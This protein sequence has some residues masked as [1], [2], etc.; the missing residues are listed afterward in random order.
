MFG[1][2]GDLQ[3]THNWKLGAAVTPEGLQEHANAQR[4]GGIN[5]W[6]YESP[7]EDVIV[8]VD[9]VKQLVETR[10][11]HETSMELDRGLSD[12]SSRANEPFEVKHF[13]VL[14]FPA[15]LSEILS[16]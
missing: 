15:F 14:I 1:H 7:F 13:A 4:D 3:D 12:I 16:V 8:R 11:I 2:F 9:D 6:H 10:Y 5:Q